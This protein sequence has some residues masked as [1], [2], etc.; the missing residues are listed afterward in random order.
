M[1]CYSECCVV[2]QVAASSGHHIWT[3]LEQCKH[4]EG[5]H[6]A[7]HHDQPGSSHAAGAQRMPHLLRAGSAGSLLPLPAQRGL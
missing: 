6:Y 3:G 4:A 2:H 5:P 1:R 7:Q